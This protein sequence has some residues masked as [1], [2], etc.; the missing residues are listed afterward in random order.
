MLKMATRADLEETDGNNMEV[1][2]S[3]S[4]ATHYPEKMDSD[5]RV[6]MEKGRKGSLAISEEL[7]DPLVATPEPELTPKST[8]KRVILSIALVLGATGTS[9]AE[10]Q[11]AKQSYSEDFNAPF[12]MMYTSQM[13]RV[14]IFPLFLLISGAVTFAKRRSFGFEKQINKA[15]LVYGPEGVTLLSLFKVTV[16]LGAS[17][18]VS[19]GLYMSTLS[20]ISP[21]ES[22]TLMTSQIAIVYVISIIFLHQRILLVKIIAT[23]VSFT[24]VALTAYVKG[25]QSDSITGIAVTLVAA[26]FYAVNQVYLKYVLKTAKLGQITLYMSSTAIFILMFGWVF[27]LTLWIAGM[28]TWSFDS[29]PWGWIAG[30][31]GATLATAIIVNYGIS[32]ATPFFMSMYNLL[33]IPINNLIDAY[34]RGQTFAEL[35]IV[36][37]VLI[38]IGFIFI[39]LPDDR[40]SIRLKK[41]SSK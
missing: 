24:G 26:T 36:G 8:G 37:A 6:T 32:V 21:S 15:I 22:T 19:L 9:I 23:V 25:F 10:S 40:V 12:L 3:S 38:A 31:G 5:K 27:P 11:L 33:R 16:V 41:Q 39:V 34:A 7:P 29:V 14:W 18:I 4:S 28:E 1:L 35:E 17:S 30:S 20:Y 2:A 13:I